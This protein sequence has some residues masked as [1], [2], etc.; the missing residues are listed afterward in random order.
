MQVGPE[1]HS[2][3]EKAHLAMGWTALVVSQCGVM[4]GFCGEQMMRQS[5]WHTT[6]SNKSLSVRKALE[7]AAGFGFCTLSILLHPLEHTFQNRASMKAIL[8]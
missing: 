4:P 5:T 1:F 2:L 8:S 6:M 7:D 3:L